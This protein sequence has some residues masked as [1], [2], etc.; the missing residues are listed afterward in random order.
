[1]FGEKLDLG[2]AG[3]KSGLIPDSD[4]KKSNLQ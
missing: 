2:F 3:E 4:W 1:M